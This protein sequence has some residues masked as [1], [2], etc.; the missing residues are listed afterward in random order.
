MLEVAPRLETLIAL[1]PIEAW[2]AWALT[3][4]RDGTKLR[5]RPISGRSHPWPPMRTA[6]A[7]CKLARMHEAPN[8]DCSCGLHGTL[9]ANVLRHAKSPAVIGTVALWGRV[10]EHEFGYRGQFA[11][12]Q[13]LRLVCHLCLWRWGLGGPR[14]DVVV[15]LP[16]GR[17]VPLCE[18]HLDVSGRYE[19]PIRPT[20]PARR[21]ESE[22]L[23]TYAV[24]LLPAG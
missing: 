20:L 1:E 5:L 12:P 17:M 10:V 24:D 16:W 15:R 13:R 7:R 6:E 11:Y 9:E 14:P 8:P 19:F 18:D 23:S 21:I 22:L 4:R 2:R 3:G